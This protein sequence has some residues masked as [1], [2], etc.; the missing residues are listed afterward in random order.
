MRTNRRPAGPL[1]ASGMV[2]LWGAS[3][4]L[5][6][7]QYGTI[8]LTLGPTTVTISDV[9]TA[10]SVVL[11]LGLSTTDT[12]ATTSRVQVSVSLTNATTV[13][14]IC[15]DGVATKIIAFAVLEF[16][17]GVVKSIQTGNLQLLAAS[18]TTVTVTEVN[19]AKAVMIWNNQ[20][21]NGATN[22]VSFGRFTYT[23]STTLTLTAGGST[24]GTVIRAQYTLLEFF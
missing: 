15:E 19:P 18:S 21:T 1:A 22:D 12:T 4:L 23:N 10:N 7:I 9:N 13:S 3:S 8:T 6:S 11:Y 20:R 5:K 2:S 24:G 14:A 17:P 16:A